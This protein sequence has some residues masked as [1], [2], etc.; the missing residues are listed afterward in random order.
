GGALMS[1]WPVLVATGAVVIGF[2]AIGQAQNASQPSG[3]LAGKA[4]FGD[5]RADAP[6]KRRHITADALPAPFAT[7]STSNG[8]RVVARPANAQL[9]VPA[10]FAI[11]RF[12][13]GLDNPRQMRV[14]P[15]GDVFVG[16]SNAGRVR[17]L[18]PAQNGAGVAQNEVFAS[19]L[20]QPFGVA[21]FPADN[22]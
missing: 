4:A 21:F 18:R 12:A 19:G 10:G 20:R 15:N 8:V 7:S 16:E 6:G 9:K 22:P 11:N 14:A 2:A 17:A 13:S 5:W 3:V 1:T